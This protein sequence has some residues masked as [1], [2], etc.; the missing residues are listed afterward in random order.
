MMS[1]FTATVFAADEIPVPG[2][3]VVQEIELPANKHLKLCPFRQLLFFM[4]SKV[5]QQKNAAIRMTAVSR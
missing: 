5:Q 4:F 2:K 3:Q 1:F